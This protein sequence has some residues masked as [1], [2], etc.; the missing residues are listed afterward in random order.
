MTDAL[1]SHVQLLLAAE[2]EIHSELGHGGMA[3]VYDATHREQGRRVAIKVLPPQKAFDQ[4]L[5]ERFIREARAAAGLDHPGIVPVYSARVTGDIAWFEMYLVQGESLAQRLTRVG[6]LPTDEARWILAEVADALDYAHRSGLVHRDV[7]P[8]NILLD[9]TT[10]QPMLT[11]FGIARAVDDDHR[12]TQDTDAI[13]TPTY[14]SPEQVLGNIDVDARA[15]VYSLGVVGYEMLTGAA[16]FMAS[17]V[18][19][20]LSMHLSQLA[21]PILERRP[22][23]PVVIAEAIGRAM[24][25]QPDD[26]WH[27]MQAFRAALGAAPAPERLVPRVTAASTTP[28]DAPAKSIRERV[29]RFRLLLVHSAVLVFLVSIMNKL[30]TPLDPLDYRYFAY[31]R[32]SEFLSTFGTI[33]AA[34]LLFRGTNLYAENVSLKELVLGFRPQGANRLLP[35]P[36]AVRPASRY[37][38]T[39][40]RAAQE[41][42]EIAELMAALPA[43]KR[44]LIEGVAPTA[45][46][47]HQ[48]VERMTAGLREIEGPLDVEKDITGSLFMRLDSAVDALRSMKKGLRKLDNAD[49]VT[50]A[51]QLNA[52]AERMRRLTD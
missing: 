2:Y 5:R 37:E 26:R 12:I 44:A 27:S 16:P 52:T 28:A 48:M 36:P 47:L 34:V 10:G 22:D 19:A 38:T 50:S 32:D 4:S 21:I 39:R 7:K 17:S 35:Q 1:L 8:D 23:T 15:D 31:V 46:A 45:L 18:P 6:R 41:H 9:Q 24:E 11:D 29:S 25:K 14:M 40:R 43:E 42:S 3:V 20:I 51:E 49:F 33:L 13:G 30:S